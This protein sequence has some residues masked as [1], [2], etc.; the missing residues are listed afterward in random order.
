[1]VQTQ[2]NTYVICIH[3]YKVKRRKQDYLLL[4]L[5]NKALRLAV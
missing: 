2:R 5:L 3:V 4:A 1:M